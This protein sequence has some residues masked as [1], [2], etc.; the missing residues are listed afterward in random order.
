MAIGTG[1]GG[2]VVI[3]VLSFTT[4]VSVATAAGTAVFPYRWRDASARAF[5][6][7]RGAALA[8]GRREVGTAQPWSLS[9]AAIRRAPFTERLVLPSPNGSAIAASVSETQVVAACLRNYSAVA[10][11]LLLQGWGSPNR[12]IAIVAA[13]EQ[14]PG[15]ETVRPAL[16][17]W[18]GAGALAAALL[19]RGIDALSPEA[20]CAASTFRALANVPALLRTS[21][22]GRELV[23][24]G[25]PDDVAIAVDL[26]ADTTVPVLDNGAFTDHS[27]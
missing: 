3:D 23:S 17:D 15:T 4:S 22:S 20:F 18:L 6:D 21:A 19:D 13:G 24:G 9:P 8:V 1:A 2:L 12:P 7:A 16:E 25:F 14:W 26:D 27:H 10:D 5:A 11:W